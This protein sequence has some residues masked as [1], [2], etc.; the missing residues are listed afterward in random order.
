M[1][2]LDQLEAEVGDADYTTT[3]SS[4]N[5]KSVHKLAT[6]YFLDTVQL[7]QYLL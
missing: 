4:T 6:P 7:H 1:Q 3:S 5:Q 2:I